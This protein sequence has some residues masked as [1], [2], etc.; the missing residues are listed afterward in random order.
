MSRKLIFVAKGFYL[1]LVSALQW[2]PWNFL[3]G[4]SQGAKNM[5]FGVFDDADYDE[6]IKSKIQNFARG[7]YLEEI[8]DP[9]MDPLFKTWIVA[10][11]SKSRFS[12]GYPEVA[13]I[14]QILTGKRWIF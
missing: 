14:V 3:I 12:I 9:L 10:R 6:N 11:I 8:L 7:S 5:D 4:W 2:C 1:S 13:I